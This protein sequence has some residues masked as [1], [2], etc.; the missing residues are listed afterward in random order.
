MRRGADPSAQYRASCTIASLRDITTRGEDMAKG[1]WIAFYRAV[2][3][4]DRLA[5]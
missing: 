3:D 4:A 1:Y 5:A 2:H